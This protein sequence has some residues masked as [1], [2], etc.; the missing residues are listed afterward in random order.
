MGHKKKKYGKW[1]ALIELGL[2][3]VLLILINLVMSTW[4]FRIDLTHEKRYSLS[5]SSKKLAGRLDDV[6]YVKVFLRGDF[7]AGFKRLSQ[8]TREMLDE[9]SAYAGGHLQYEFIDPFA[10]ADAK[11]SSDVVKELVAKGLQ[12]TNVQ[13]KKDDEMAQKIIVPGALF[14][15]KGREYPVNL[16]KGQFGAAPEEVIN[17]SIEL[18]EYEIANMLRKATEKSLRRIAFTDDHGE[19]GRWDVADAQAEL[20]QFYEVKRIP[21]SSV[22]P[23]ELN[24][25][26]G[27][28][29]A[30][31]T[32]PFSDYDKFKLDQY[33]MNGG[34]ILWLVETQ[35]ADMDSLQNEPMFVSASYELNLE[36]LLFRYGVRVNPN[37]VQDIQCEA[38]PVLSAVRS[39]TPQQKLLPWLFY[40]VVSPANDHPIVKNIDPVWFQFASSIDTTSNKDIRKTVLLRT[41]PYARLMGA[42]V[43]V[44]LN[45]VRVR[46]D[47]DLFSK[48]SFPLAVLLEGKFKS[49][50]QYRFGASSDPELPFRESIE[51][52]KMIVVSDGEVIR[53]QRKQ[54]TGEIYPLGYNRYTNQQFGNKRFILNC[55]DYL[56]DDS[57]I[58]E[59]RGKEITLRLLNKAKIK[60]EKFQWQLINTLTPLLLVVLFG[61]TNQYIRK[62]KYTRN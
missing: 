59:V 23:Q 14:F 27:I 32:L 51:H 49:I 58:L 16:L 50:F 46:P 22:P 41:S 30:K 28:V 10:D 36:D 5:E 42:P 18:I 6:M 11:K 20:E 15:Y 56:C 31:P 7:P 12:P 47:P 25:Y 48:G 45:M 53:N 62:R 8:A 3:L 57:G 33:V 1:Q 54:S 55:M 61:L 60:K 52:N 17:S 9:F 43:R 13:I 37:M 4:F 2:M 19:L 26:A 24:H 40:P 29:I 21:L 44:D 38:I 39:G 34:K 35:L